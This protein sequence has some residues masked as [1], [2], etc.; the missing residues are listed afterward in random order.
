MVKLLTPNWILA[1]KEK[2]QPAAGGKILKICLYMEG[3]GGGVARKKIQISWFQKKKT[4]EGSTEKEAEDLP[5]RDE[6]EGGLSAGFLAPWV[7]LVLL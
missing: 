6:D 4:M 1:K 3:G 2:N 5:H 7:S